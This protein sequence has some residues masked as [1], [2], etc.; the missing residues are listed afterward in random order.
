M[1]LFS[2][3]FSEV[4]EGMI[5]HHHGTFLFEETH[6]AHRGLILRQFSA[7]VGG[8]REGQHGQRWQANTF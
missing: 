5:A 2:N 8:R 6:H 3:S 7:E 1:H 4:L